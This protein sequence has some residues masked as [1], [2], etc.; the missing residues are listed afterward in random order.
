MSGSRLALTRCWMAGLRDDGG[1]GFA[2]DW[3]WRRLSARVMVALRH[4]LMDG[5]SRGHLASNLKTS[6]MW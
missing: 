3:K 5:S 4:A 6:G 2:R 1:R